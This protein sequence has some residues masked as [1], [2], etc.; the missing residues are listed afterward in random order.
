MCGP[1]DFDALNTSITRLAG[2]SVAGIATYA[3][4][5]TVSIY[6]RQKTKAEARERKAPARARRR[7]ALADSR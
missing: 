6:R 1:V 4:S 7:I 2:L 5:K 3:V